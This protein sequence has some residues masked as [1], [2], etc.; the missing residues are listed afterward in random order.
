MMAKGLSTVTGKVSVVCVTAGPGAT[1]AIPG[2]AECWV[3]S[4]P[5]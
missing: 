5:L 1:N 2:L 3:D 4:S